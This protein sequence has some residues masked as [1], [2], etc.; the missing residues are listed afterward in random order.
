M[1]TTMNEEIGN[2]NAH[3]GKH[4]FKG[5][6]AA[7]YLEKHGLDRE[8][9]NG[10]DWAKNGQAP[11]V[12]AA[13]LDW[14]RDHGA[15]TFC[16]WFQPLGAGGLRHGNSA[17]VQNRM[18]KFDKNGS[19]VWDFSANDLLYGETDGSSYLNGG[20]RATHRA[21]GYVVID[22]TS[23]IFLRG[24]TIFIPSCFVSYNGHC[25]DEKTP[26]L[27]SVEAMSREG[28][29]LLK[30][31]GYNVKGLV[32]NI[33]L[34]Q[35]FFFVPRAAYLRR[36]DLQLAG[37]T[38]LGRHAARG[39]EGSDHY[40]APPAATSPPLECM[41]EIQ[42]QAYLMGIPLIT[43]HR[44]V[45][46]GQYE[47]APF[48]GFVT[49]QI[50]Q[51]LM[52]MQIM[53]E[54]AKTYGL[55]CLLQEKPFEGINGSGKHNNWSIGTDDG[56][57]LFNVK[58]LAER[59]GST[60]IFPVV[61]AAVMAAVDEYGDLMRM[62]ICPP[63][64][65]FRL[66]ACEAPPSIMSMYLGESMTRYM[67]GYRD[68]VETPYNPRS[69]PFSLGID[70]LPDVMIPAEDRNRTSPFPYGGHRFEFRAVG[71]SQNVSLVNT[72]LGTICAKSFKNFADQIEAGA[73]AR[74]VAQNSLKE[75]WRIVFNGNGYDQNCQRELI[76]RGL[77][78]INNGVDAMKRY[79]VEKN[80]ALFEEMK[81]FS[82]EECLARADVMFTHYNQ[83]VE[84]EV[85]CMVDMIVQHIIPGLRSAGVGPISELEGA[86]KKL[87]H[88]FD[89]IHHTSESE[90]KAQLSR[91][92]RLETM[93][94]VR[95]ICT[96]AE[97]V[98][99]ANLWTLATYRELLF[100]DQCA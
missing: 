62:S 45:A 29:R 19:L 63:G 16:H 10:S 30:L 61:M 67:E 31:L 48:F 14:A 32:C 27:R 1:S 94:E 65:D 25:L 70:A 90:E 57:N 9:L 89:V 84:I 17:G 69:T 12:A 44:E 71:S 80:I 37:R 34:E 5:D 96:E 20:L 92:L 15:S 85:K 50:D 56:T 99:P 51:N 28:T 23:P 55:A 2:I 49:T 75:H 21:G 33:G 54:V 98:C 72:V 11:Q 43:R 46:P 42:R 3:Y 93:I 86:V 78:S 73:S 81:V 18:F 68:G 59:S 41:K 79:K 26:L 60:E 39:Q 97:R 83:V 7:S 52:L 8:T 4:L 64:N 38:L 35:E 82:R 36:P 53:E 13:V 40:Y 22:P 66:G 95:K 87:E 58:Q 88:D 47:F 100:I 74:T 6:V 24:D 77:W 76:E 91:T